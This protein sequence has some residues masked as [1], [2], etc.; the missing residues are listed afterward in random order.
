MQVET[1]EIEESDEVSTPAVEQE[2]IELIEKLNLAGQKSLVRVDES[3]RLVRIPYPKM[4]AAE[5]HVYDAIFPTHT[6]VV[7]YDAGIIPIRVL[8]V[9]SHAK[10]LFSDV[11]VWHRRVK[12]P[13]PILVGRTAGREKY[14]LARW[15]D[16]L[17]PFSE[18][19]EEA[20]QIL[21]VQFKVK[22][23][24]R[25][26]DIQHKIA[27]VDTLVEQHLNGEYVYIV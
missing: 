23:Q 7:R 1:F 8:Q 21:R 2:A 25:A 4:T 26:S 14:L 10:E 3:D 16:A 9:I 12:D 17:K 15:G 24:E 13:D 5:D 6:S 19:V 20:R 11:E 27:V 22:L 18:L